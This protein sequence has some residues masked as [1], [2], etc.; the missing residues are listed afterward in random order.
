[1]WSRTIE[2]RNK[3]GLFGR[4]DV[5]Q[6]N[7]GRL[8]A[9]GAGLISH[10][11]DVAHHIQRI[12]AQLHVRQVGLHDQLGVAWVGHIHARKVFWRRFMRQ[13]EDAAPIA[14]QLHGH[15]LPQTTKARKLV[16]REQLHVERKGLIRARRG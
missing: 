5:K 10:R 6:V 9:N 16:V 3:F 2:V 11:H 13:P 15:A 12:G 14:C 4:A 1:M 7:S 8:D